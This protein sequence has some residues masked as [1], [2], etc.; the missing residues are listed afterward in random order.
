MGDGLITTT[1][2][3]STIYGKSVTKPFYAGA[4]QLE[5]LS[6]RSGYVR[7]YTKVTTYARGLC[8]LTSLAPTCCAG[9][10]GE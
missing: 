4:Y 9:H 3:L 8:I 2:T 6:A 5:I 1:Q 7:V 10:A